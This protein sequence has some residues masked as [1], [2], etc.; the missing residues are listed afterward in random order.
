MKK[1]LKFFAFICVVIAFFTMLKNPLLVKRSGVTVHFIDVGQG[2]SIFLELPDNKCMLID[3][4]EN[5]K[6]KDVVGYI[7]S[8]GV[9]KIDYLIG[10]HPHSD[11]IGGL[12]NVIEE[13]DIGS[14]YM[15]KVSHTSKTYEDVLDIIAKKGYKIKQAKSGV[16][17]YS[18]EKLNIDIISPVNEN[19]D[20]LNEYSAVVKLT[21]GDTKFLFMG[22]AENINENEIEGD[23]SADV[24]K[25][26]HHGSS[27]ST[28]KKFLKRVSPKIALISVGENNDYGHPHKE[29][30]EKL[31]N[32]KTEVLRT[33]K[34]GTIILNS[35]SKEVRRVK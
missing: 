32:E 9:R 30:I 8:L 22:D 29:T 17:I 24:L 5:K 1:V 28:S 18:D 14:I 27:S 4:G 31:E 10:T 26:G 3:A 6:G 11:H 33:D 21:Y 2:D 34:E 16:N 35:D 12:D 15:P 7:K 19:Y 13:F 25:I 23:I 20:S